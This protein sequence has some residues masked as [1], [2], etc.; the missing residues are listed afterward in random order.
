MTFLTVHLVQRATVMQPEPHTQDSAIASAKGD[1]ARLG[2]EKKFGAWTLL[3]PGVN[4]ELFAAHSG[5]HGG[6]CRGN[7][8]RPHWGTDDNDTITFDGSN[9]SIDGG[10]G[11]TL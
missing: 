6:L 9:V 4:F 5:R 8:E 3:R 11:T 7:G 2:A 1:P 10:A